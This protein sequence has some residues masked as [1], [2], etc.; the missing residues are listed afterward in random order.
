MKA[1]QTEVDGV[2]A[3]VADNDADITALQTA[4]GNAAT[5]ADLDAVEAKVDANAADIST[6]Q[7]ESATKM[8][9][10]DQATTLRGEIAAEVA[11]LEQKDMDNFDALSGMISMVQQELIDGDAALQTQINT[12]NANLASEIMRVEVAFAAADTALGMQI[13]TVESESMTRD[14]AIEARITS[15]VATLNTAIGANTTLIN[16][17]LADKQ[18]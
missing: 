16:T 18:T 10:A 5:Q 3:D 4:V 17:G 12:T 7:T 6:L 14:T 2:K 11:A 15:E 1:D 13:S 8:E 9:L